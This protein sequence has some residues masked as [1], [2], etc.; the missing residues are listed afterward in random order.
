MVWWKVVDANEMV[1]EPLL[2]VFSVEGHGS[3]QFKR[4]G[5][6][7]N[8]NLRVG[9]ERNAVDSEG[10]FAAL[11]EHGGGDQDSGKRGKGLSL[12]EV[13]VVGAE[14]VRGMC[15]DEQHGILTLEFG[16]RTGGGGCGQYS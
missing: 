2:I 10:P 15:N 11:R 12:P 9:G 6:A 14:R 5:E 3:C 8:L 13:W 16:C 4:S 1:R 7:G